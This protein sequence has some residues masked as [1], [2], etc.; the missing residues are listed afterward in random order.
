MTLFV[1]FNKRKS[2]VHMQHLLLQKFG[3]WLVVFIY[4]TIGTFS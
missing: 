2:I 1:P 3:S 4:I